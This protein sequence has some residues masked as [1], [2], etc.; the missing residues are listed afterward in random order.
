MPS[1][2]KARS[3]VRLLLIATLG[4]A[5]CGLHFSPGIEAKADW[6]RRYTLAVGGTV[7]IQNTNGRVEV[8][9]TDGDAV[10]VVAT[11]VA[12]GSDEAEAKQAVEKIEIREKVSD[13]RVVLD[14][15]GGAG[16]AAAF[17]RSQRV[18]YVVRMPRRAN[19]TLKTT[20]GE[21]DVEGVAG[22]VD[23]TT[24]NGQIRL[25]GL[26][27]KTRVETGNGQVTLDVA[28]LGEDG[29]TCHTTNG[30]INLTVPRNL[31][32]DLSARVTNGAIETGNLE[33]VVKEQS[34]KRLDAAL[35]GGGPEIK[36]ETTNGAIEIRGK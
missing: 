23:V 12:R 2:P 33:L 1:R 21:V 20:N 17:A 26:A 16:L 31:P 29:L 28:R 34:R 15:T 22:A 6:T 11:R 13:D 4:A 3:L 5:G 27:G 25:M 24:T 10:E 30:V 8:R 32:A 9:T 14:S 7:E 36:L 19:L 18:D 35:A